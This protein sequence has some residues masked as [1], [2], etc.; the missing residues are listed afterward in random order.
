MRISSIHAI[1]VITVFG[2]GFSATAMGKARQTDFNGDGRADLAIGVPQEH[3]GGHDFA[4]G[5]AVMYGKN[6]N[7]L[8]AAGDQFWTADSSGVNGESEDDDRFGISVAVGDFDGDGFSDLAIGVSG[9][10]VNGMAQAGAVE[11]LYGSASGLRSNGDQ[12]WSRNSSGVLGDA[13]ANA[14]FGEVLAAG[15]FDHDG[16]DDLAIGVVGETVNGHSSAGEVHILYGGS[17]GLS[18]SGDQIFNQDSAGISDS[19]EDNDY[20]GSALCTGDFDGN[21]KDDLAIGVPFEDAGATTEIGLVHVIYGTSHGLDANGAQVFAEG[22]GGLSGTG[23]SSEFFG[24]AFAAGDFDG[25]HK[26]DLAISAWGE[27]VNGQDMAGMVYVLYGSSSGLKTAGSQQ[28]TQDSDGVKDSSEAEDEFGRALA[29]GDFD[30]DGK[31]DL[32][33]GVPFEDVGG[34]SDAGA[35]NVLYGTSSGLKA[36]GNQFWTQDSEDI[37]DHCETDDLFGL[38]LAA[39]DYNHDGRDDLVIGGGNESLHG[40]TE[41]G[42]VNVIYGHNSNGLNHDGNQFWHQDSS[43]INDS[44]QEEDLFGYC[45]K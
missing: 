8:N 19:A 7:G 11:V 20:F 4:G 28:W 26:D 42:A 39:G 27:D 29:A 24:Y 43:G 2:A 37:K 23:A 40:Q 3:V 44:C 30:N 9:K 31:D 38:A 32:A 36:T 25:N 14:F 45:L 33:I 12:L 13:E 10:T 21:G 5:V 6:S 18:G 1:V 15:D 34:V 22:L 17:Q 16:R 35:V 41:C